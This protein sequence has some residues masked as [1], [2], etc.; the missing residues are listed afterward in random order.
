MQYMW[1][2][3]S[4]VLR[5]WALHLG[6]GKSGSIF[7]INQVSRI[8]SIYYDQGVCAAACAPLRQ[9]LDEYLE[10]FLPLVLGQRFEA[11]RAVMARLESSAPDS[12]SPHLWAAADLAEANDVVVAFR[13]HWKMDAATTAAAG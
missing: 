3:V 13:Q 10:H 5:S 8:R 9:L 1:G 12:G 2:E 6:E 7:V 4:R 11:M